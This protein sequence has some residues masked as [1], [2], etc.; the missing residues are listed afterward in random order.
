VCPRRRSAGRSNGTR[1]GQGQVRAGTTFRPARTR[2]AQGTRGPSCSRGHDM[3]P[4]RPRGAHRRRRP[5]IPFDRCCNGF[6]YQLREAFWDGP[7]RGL[8]RALPKTR[9]KLFP[10][11][12]KRNVWER[13]ERGVR[14]L[15]RGASVPKC[16]RDERAETWMDRPSS[17][18]CPTPS[19][20]AVTV[21]RSNSGKLFGPPRGGARAAQDAFQ[22]VSHAHQEKPL[23]T[24]GA[25]GATPLPGRA[26]Q[27]VSRTSEPK[28]ALHSRC[29]N[30]RAPEV[31]PA[32]CP[33]GH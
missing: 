7:P 24:F 15:P 21:S 20:A 30:P 4:A 1:A 31:R 10:T 5:S 25:G 23:G 9:S 2:G 16:L 11:R 17:P 33:P 12:T 8:G 13:S 26:S 14:H 32:S 29:D 27:N 3:R 22:I 19:T 28:P 18:E 6:A